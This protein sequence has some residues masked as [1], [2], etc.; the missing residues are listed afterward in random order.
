MACSVAPSKLSQRLPTR[1][2]KSATN[3]A[4]AL[5]LRIPCHTRKKAPS[6]YAPRLDAAIPG[7]VMPPEVPG[8]TGL[9]VVIRRGLDALN[10][11]SSVAQV[12]ALAV[13]SA[14]V[15]PACARR[16]VR[17]DRA[18]PYTIAKSV[19]SPPLAVACARSRLAPLLNLSAAALALSRCR[20]WESRLDETKK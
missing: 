16:R 19:A 12:S 13:A 2:L 4:G 7:A 9:P 1:P 5:N 18:R 10:T 3:G 8:A 15:K 17:G 6:E 14:P 11:P 20:K